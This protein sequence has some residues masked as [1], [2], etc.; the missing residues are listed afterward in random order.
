MNKFK[1][2]KRRL[3]RWWLFNKPGAIVRNNR[4]Y[5]KGDFIKGLNSALENE[6]LQE[7]VGNTK[8]YGEM[9]HV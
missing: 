9:P 5:P 3:G 2:W 6:A 7:K 4:V 1:A 8:L